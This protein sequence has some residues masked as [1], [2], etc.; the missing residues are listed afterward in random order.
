MLLVVAMT[1]C[2]ITQ[3]DLEFKDTS[4]FSAMC[5]YQGSGNGSCMKLASP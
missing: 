3:H 5:T 2:D 4:A 1:G